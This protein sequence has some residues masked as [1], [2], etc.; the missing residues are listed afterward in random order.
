VRRRRS[1]LAGPTRPQA[2]SSRRRERSI[3]LVPVAP[4]WSPIP[5]ARLCAIEV[6]LRTPAWPDPGAPDERSRRALSDGEGDAPV[7]PDCTAADRTRGAR[8]RSAS[9]STP[10]SIATPVVSV[11][12]RRG[13]FRL[14][15]Y[16]PKI[17]YRDAAVLAFR[18]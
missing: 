11:C 4:G 9:R 2:E 18:D 6:G 17:D 14:V 16:G 5:A 8:G 1:P 7:C 15:A 3:D 13:A 12:G 10:K